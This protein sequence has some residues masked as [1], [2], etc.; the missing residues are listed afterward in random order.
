M[1]EVRSGDV[2]RL[3][4]GKEHKNY[5]VGKVGKDFLKLLFE[6]GT[7]TLVHKDGLLVRDGLTGFE[8]LRNKQRDAEFSVGSYVQ[9]HLHSG[10]IIVGDVVENGDGLL[11]I[12]TTLGPTIYVDLETQGD[13]VKMVVLAE[14]L[15]DFDAF[16]TSDLPEGLPELLTVRLQPSPD[17]AGRRVALRLHQPRLL[18]RSVVPKWFVPVGNSAMLHREVLVSSEDDAAFLQKVANS[19]NPVEVLRSVTVKKGATPVSEPTAVVF[20]DLGNFLSGKVFKADVE[21]FEP[22]APVK[23]Y[24]AVQPLVPLSRL[25]L[26]ATDLAVKVRL[27]QQLQKLFSGWRDKT[28]AAPRFCNL[29]EF[30]KKHQP[31]ATG[32][33]RYEAFRA[34][35][36]YQLPSISAKNLRPKQKAA[37]PPSDLNTPTPPGTVVAASRFAFGKTY[38]HL[39]QQNLFTSESLAQILHLDYG[40]LFFKRTGGDLLQA[41]LRIRHGGVWE[42][43]RL[44][45]RLK[46]AGGKIQP[47]EPTFLAL[48]N[49]V[50]DN[51]PPTSEE[52]AARAFALLNNYTREPAEGEDA[53]WLYHAT[54]GEKLVPVS[55]ERLV[56]AAHLQGKYGY[57]ALLQTFQVVEDGRIV[58][59]ATGAILGERP[60]PPIAVRVT[61][62]QENEPSFKSSAYDLSLVNFLESL[63]CRLGVTLAENRD[64]VLK[65]SVWKAYNTSAS[66]YTVAGYVAYYGGKGS[67]A[68]AEVFRRLVTTRRDLHMFAEAAAVSDLSDRVNVQAENAKRFDLRPPASPS[69]P[70]GEEGSALLHEVEQVQPT[71]AMGRV[72]KKSKVTPVV[73]VPPTKAEIFTIPTPEHDPPTMHEELKKKVLARFPSAKLFLAE[74][75]VSALQMADFVR[76]LTTVIPSLLTSKKRHF[77]NINNLLPKGTAEGARG[78]VANLYAPLVAVDTDDAP[79]SSFVRFARAM[80]THA[81]NFAA[82]AASAHAAGRRDDISALRS[83]VLSALYLYFE[84]DYGKELIQQDDRYVATVV[85]AAMASVGIKSV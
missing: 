51:L 16:D 81:K 34:L 71:L 11:T 33:S 75:L 54:S 30:Q 78:A 4:F 79:D 55:V 35:E 7:E 27:H 67:G 1:T 9:V 52:K 18:D 73:F 32:P 60:T 53:G 6:G 29:A 84:A 22:T 65:R 59:P 72:G 44:A 10:G 68:V 19:P 43:E 24:A 56:R 76:M 50:G 15:D 23:N 47:Y 45:Q 36:P 2:L 8:V 77:R 80:A 42:R 12:H 70:P 64:L 3:F 31:R 13:A 20:H 26:P 46:K 48:L 17:A 58:D 40:R 25:F 63:C 41:L 82:I 83:C 57:S 39:L 38:G 66:A 37:K 85:E 21:V 28:K 49:E 69:C 74:G 14:S 5:L 62:S 61:E